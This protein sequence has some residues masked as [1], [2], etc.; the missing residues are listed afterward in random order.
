MTHGTKDVRNTKTTLSFG[1]NMTGTI[2]LA[3][4]RQPATLSTA[5]TAAHVHTT[6]T[7]E[8]QSRHP[9][10]TSWRSEHATL[11]HQ[12]SPPCTHTSLTT[13]LPLTPLH[14]AI[15]YHAPNS[16]PPPTTLLPSPPTNLSTPSH[17]TQRSL[18]PLPCIPPYHHPATS[19]PA[20]DITILCSR[21]VLEKNKY[22]CP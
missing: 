21:G 6:L 14:L 3:P 22:L 20:D 9:L 16:Y 5:V 19:P 7:H 11:P 4:T 2:G 12:H 17:P 15:S 13:H 10:L 1:S 8:E 18:H